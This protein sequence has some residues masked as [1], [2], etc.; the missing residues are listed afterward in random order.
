VLR[1]NGT[2]IMIERSRFPFRW[3]KNL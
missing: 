1:P 3:V 2:P